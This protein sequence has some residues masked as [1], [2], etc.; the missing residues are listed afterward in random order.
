V[1][2]QSCQRLVK[3]QAAN[4]SRKGTAIQSTK[5]LEFTLFCMGGGETCNSSKN[6]PRFA[7]FERQSRGRSLANTAETVLTAGNYSQSFF[8]EASAQLSLGQISLQLA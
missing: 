5:Q 2:I 4:K 3:N 8:P 6:Q 7:T 1:L